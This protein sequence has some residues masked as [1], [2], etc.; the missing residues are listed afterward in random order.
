MEIEL[1]LCMHKNVREVAVV[2]KQLHGEAV[3]SAYFVLY[4]CDYDMGRYMSTLGKIYR[5][6]WF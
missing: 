1:K 6:I 5:I 4:R 2:L 3:L